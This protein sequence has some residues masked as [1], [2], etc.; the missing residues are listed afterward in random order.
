M[1]DHNN[2]NKKQHLIHS[3]N[4]MPLKEEHGKGVGDHKVAPISVQQVSSGGTLPSESSQVATSATAT[5]NTP[6]AAVSS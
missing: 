5:N 1:A 2:S 6:L 3:D 4:N